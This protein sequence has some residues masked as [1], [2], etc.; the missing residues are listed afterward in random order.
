MENPSTQ[1]VTWIMSPSQLV[2]YLTCPRS[3]YFRRVARLPEEEDVDKWNYGHRLHEVCE[4]WVSGDSRGRDA[5]GEPVNL[6]P[7]GWQQKSIDLSEE[8][9]LKVTIEKATTGAQQ[10]LRRMPDREVE[11]GYT[12][13]V[14][15][16]VMMTGKI[17]VKHRAGFEDHKTTKSRRWIST[18]AKLAKDDKMLCYAY[19]TIL[20]WWEEEGKLDPE[21]TVNMRFNYFSKDPS[22]VFVKHVDV[23]VRADEV[24]QWW[25]DTVLPAA[26]DM[27][28]MKKENLPAAEWSKVE[29][30]RRP[31]ACQAYGGCKFAEI[32]TRVKTPEKYSQRINRINE[33]RK[34]NQS[35]P[36][37]TTM[38]IFGKT[39][40]RKDGKVSKTDTVSP[41][42][43]KQPQKDAEGAKS[44]A[45]ASVALDKGDG[46]TKSVEV[47]A[48]PWARP[49]CK[50]CG[51]T[52]IRDNK[53][54]GACDKINGATGKMTSADFEIVYTD[55][56]LVFAGE[57]SSGEI[58]F[59]SVKVEEIP[60]KVSKTEK[61]GPTPEEKEAEK[62]AAKAAKKKAAAEK[63]AEK[64]AAKKAKVD[65]EKAAEDAGKFDKHAEDDDGASSLDKTP[66]FP[67]PTS[68][69]LDKVT[70]L[71]DEIPHTRAILFINCIPIGRSVTDL[72]EVVRKEGA[73]LAEDMGKESYYDIVA[74]ERRALLAAC[75]NEVY[76]ELRGAIYV[77]TGDAD[78]DA[79]LAAIRPFFKTIIVGVR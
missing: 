19:E 15:P 34:K 74:Y 73:D 68:E 31:N 44:E 49:K 50:A 35:Q 63:R 79:Y 47:V 1:I 14:I 77:Q 22:D 75:A 9:L 5:T 25:E 6:Y 70:E 57:E 36:I 8:Q 2:D 17:D 53:P 12:R 61:V 24:V 39:K 40:K 67:E 59:A 56:A 28:R 7:E 51:G 30:P 64:K 43:D 45:K 11:I 58:P 33:S 65:A 41:S 38:S 18:Q 76:D 54:C 29:G 66:E 13:E 52:G 23:D 60:A 78:V 4:R 48:A 72:A 69:A 21:R 55:N 62:E 3:W 42:S 10:V 27:L 37:P 20:Q 32:C 26:E 71:Q 16:N 46:G